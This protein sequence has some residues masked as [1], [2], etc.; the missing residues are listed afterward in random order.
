MALNVSNCLMVLAEI[1]ICSNANDYFS[2]KPKPCKTGF[3]GSV[4]IYGPK[5]WEGRENVSEINISG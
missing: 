2:R 4:L 3:F 1:V 5:L